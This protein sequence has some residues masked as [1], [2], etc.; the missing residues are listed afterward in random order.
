MFDPGNEYPSQFS[1]LA[2]NDLNDLVRIP[3]VEGYGSLTDSGYQSATGT[4]THNTLSP[5]ALA[6]GYFVPLDLSTVVTVSDDLIQKQGSPPATLTSVPST[7]C[8]VSRPPGNDVWWFGRPLSIA[9]ASVSYTGPAAVPAAVRVGLVSSTGAT[10]WTTAPVK[11]SAGRL[12]I[13][14]ASPVTGSGLVVAGRGTP[15]ATDATTVTTASG[16]TYIMDGLLQSALRDASFHLAGYG[17]GIAVFRTTARS[18]PISLDATGADT[19]TT[20]AGS[21]GAGSVGV[22]VVRRVDLTSWGRETDAVTV[23]RP[24]DLVRSEAFSVG[25]QARVHN[26][27]TRRSVTLPVTRLGLVQD[28]HL[29]PGSYTVTWAYRPASVTAGLLCTL[30]GSLVVA[31]A[32]ASWLWYRLRRRHR[33]QPRGGVDAEG[34]DA[35]GADDRN[36]RPTATPRAP[37]ASSEAAIRG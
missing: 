13:A 22:G 10:D 32:A 9:S 6:E 8:P 15:H 1:L 20:G 23:R 26:T 21:V 14:F 5:C 7:P 30:A 29:D 19:G 11:A 4:R 37:A 24:A 18:A 35:D 27:V 3:S 17:D 33:R 16:A 25:W 34:L 12:T 2:Q 31:G 28:V 36:V